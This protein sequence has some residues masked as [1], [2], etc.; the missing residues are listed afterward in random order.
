MHHHHS[1]L[2]GDQVVLLQVH[3]LAANLLGF[4][5]GIKTENN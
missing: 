5:W 2:Q 3:Q 1:V 4:A